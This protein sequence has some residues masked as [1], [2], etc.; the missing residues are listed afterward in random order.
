MSYSGFSSHWMLKCD[1]PTFSI[2]IDSI[3]SMSMW[4]V[5]LSV[6]AW[7]CGLRGSGKGLDQDRPKSALATYDYPYST[8]KVGEDAGNSL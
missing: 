1:L 3:N 2:V 4:E 6:P 7:V 5:L 8:P